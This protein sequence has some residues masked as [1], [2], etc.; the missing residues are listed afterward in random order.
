MAVDDDHQKVI[1]CGDED[2]EEDDKKSL[3]QPEGHP[4]PGKHREIWKIR[5]GVYAQ[6]KLSGFTLTSKL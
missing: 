3:G 1:K 5:R 4:T 2:A 6:H